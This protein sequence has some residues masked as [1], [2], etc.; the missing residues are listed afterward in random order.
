MVYSWNTSRTI[1]IFFP[2]VENLKKN[3]TCLDILLSFSKSVYIKLFNKKK[4]GRRLVE[5]ILLFLVNILLVLTLIIFL[6]NLEITFLGIIKIN[7]Q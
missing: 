5:D 4:T 2:I 6:I 1:S 3:T 7:H